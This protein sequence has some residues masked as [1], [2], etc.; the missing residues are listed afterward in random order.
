MRIPF[1]FKPPKLGLAYS[2]VEVRS[3]ELADA[4]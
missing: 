1:L 2:T 4:I 3:K